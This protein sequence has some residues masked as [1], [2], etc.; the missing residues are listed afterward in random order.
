[1]LDSSDALSSEL[2]AR[3]FSHLSP[4]QWRPGTEGLEEDLEQYPA[5]YKLQLVCKKFEGVF[6]EH[7]CLFGVLFLRENVGTQALPGLLAWL[8]RHNSDISLLHS[9]CRGVCADVALTSLVGT[10]QLTRADLTSPTDSVLH[11]LSMCNSLT[12]C[13]LRNPAASLDLDTLKRLPKLVYLALYEGRFSVPPT[14]QLTTLSLFDAVAHVSV[15]GKE[16]S[17]LQELVMKI[18]TLKGLED[19]ISTFTGLRALTSAGSC[20]QTSKAACKMSTGGPSGVVFRGLSALTQ[21]T[22]LALHT[23]IG[24]SYPSLEP[25]YVL[26]SLKFLGL[27]GGGSLHVTTE[28]SSLINL[29][30]LVVQ[31]ICNHAAKL[32][33]QWSHMPALQDLRLRQVD[34]STG[35]MEA[36]TYLKDLRAV[37]FISIQALDV[38]STK[39]FARLIY[40]LGTKRPDIKFTIT[41]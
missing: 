10:Q 33:V 2:W 8:Q 26:D 1:M 31:G 36:L 7:H 4:N 12:A 22:F 30:R 40:L 21:L 29:T 24:D 17:G 19:G 3:V 37:D 39:H 6:R 5:L 20:A 11:I 18:S 32:T 23:V 28:L 35:D 14:S 41:C 27:S 34:F 15:V 38:L 13:T 9:L 16:G 25:V